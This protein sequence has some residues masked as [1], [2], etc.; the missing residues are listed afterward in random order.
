[1]EA[2][3]ALRKLVAARNVGIAGRGQKQAA[4]GKKGQNLENIWKETVEAVARG[5]DDREKQMN[6]ID[7]IRVDELEMDFGFDG[8]S[9]EK[10]SARKEDNVADRMP[11][12]ESGMTVNYEKKYWRKAST[13][14]SNG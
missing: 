8:G 10:P 1:M 13:V 12:I 3:R 4:R 2:E 14:M 7:G 11:D 9:D 5:D 6:R